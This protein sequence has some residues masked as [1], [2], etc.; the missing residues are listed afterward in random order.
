MKSAA[1]LGPEEAL[2]E[3]CAALLGICA[4]LLGICAAP[5]RVSEALR[6]RGKD[7]PEISG[8]SERGA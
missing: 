4:A 2:L 1:L 6:S 8:E 5:R 3:I 7:S